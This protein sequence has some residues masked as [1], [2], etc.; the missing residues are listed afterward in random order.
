MAVSKDVVNMLNFHRQ[1]RTFKKDIVIKNSLN[2]HYKT[3]EEKNKAAEY[4]IDKIP[5]DRDRLPTR[6]RQE[7]FSKVSLF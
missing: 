7:L 5:Y 4:V 1:Y 6:R 3:E 2:V